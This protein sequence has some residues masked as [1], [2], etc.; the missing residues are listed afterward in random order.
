MEPSTRTEHETKP[1]DVIKDEVKE[2]EEM[3][4]LEKKPQEKVNG[5]QGINRIHK[6]EITN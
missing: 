1:E 5:A 2:L 3:A 6:R 4:K